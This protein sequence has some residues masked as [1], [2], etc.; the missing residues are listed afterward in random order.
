MLPMTLP[1]LYAVAAS[2]PA[3]YQNVTTAAELYAA[4]SGGDV[5]NHLVW[6]Q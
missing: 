4:V 5:G 1:I 6:L 3:G 2:M